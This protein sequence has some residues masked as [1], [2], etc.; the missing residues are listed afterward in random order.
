MLRIRSS[1]RLQNASRRLYSL[2]AEP[3]DPSPLAGSSPAHDGHLIVH[4]RVPPKEW[5]SKVLGISSK[6]DD[7]AI[8]K[9]LKQAGVLVGLAFNPNADDNEDCQIYPSMGATDGRSTSK[10]IEQLNK[11]PKNN[12][13]HIYI[14]THGSRD[15]RCAE[16]G[17]PTIEKLREDVLKRGLSDKVHLYEISHIGGHKW[18]LILFGKHN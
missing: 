5:P 18:V 16:A 11:S 2:Q 13:I 12:D 10:I 1:L 4:T 6:Y 17:E 7:L 3:F 9:E 8:N 15:C 14:C